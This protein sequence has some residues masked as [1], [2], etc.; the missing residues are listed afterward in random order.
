MPVPTPRR[1]ALSTTALA[2]LL[3]AAPAATV[4]AQ[5]CT[6]GVAGGLPTL[7]CPDAGTPPVASDT[8]DLQ[9]TVEAGASILSDTRDAPPLALGGTNQTVFNDGL[10]RNSDPRNNT[11]AIA[12]TGNALTVDNA[13]M[14]ES[15]DRAVH[16]LGGARDFTLLNRA[17]GQIR[18]RR[19]AVRTEDETASMN[20]RVENHG[21]IDSSNGRAVQ[22]RGTGS[23]V[24]NHGTLL[25]GEEVIEGRLDFTVENHGLIA[26]HG[27]SFDR[28][29]MTWTD[30]GAVADEDGVQFASGRIDN[31]GII[32]STD[33]G[34]DID[35]GVVHNHASGVIISAGPDTV[36]SS[37]GID[38]DPVLQIPGLPGAEHPP[39]GRV[40]VINEGFIEGPR[41]IVS[42]LDSIAPIDIAN[43]G[44]LSGRSGIAIDLAPGQGDTTIALSGGSR[45][46][47][48]ILFGDG[49]RNTLELGLF[50]EGAEMA[51]RIGARTAGD[52]TAGL[53][54]FAGLS[55]GFELQFDAAV[56]LADFGR[57]G[58]GDNRLSL[59]MSA[60]AGMLRFDLFGVRGVDFGGARYN[61]RQFA[62]MLSENG[63]APIPLPAGVWLVL[64]GLGALVA[65][66][67]RRA[68]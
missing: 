17:G 23:T 24:I 15:G 35:E 16:V 42:A 49:G 58:L 62:A 5:T 11:N 66:R 50:D 54:D 67:R 13:G 31:H 8:D 4:Q 44:T 33:D 29:T 68:A 40:S 56:S 2:L 22:M 61:A 28:A 34:V 46:L 39:A 38:I 43:T 64:G 21:L 53:S 6:D 60:G 10:I 52:L 30:T 48:D 12:G 9:V 26:L 18:A 7:T 27:L 63:V 51:G 20:G 1:L 55:G 45:V 25:G 57:F 65:L 47:G 59:E 36:R 19:Q 32:M 41:A 3:V 37:G 14:I